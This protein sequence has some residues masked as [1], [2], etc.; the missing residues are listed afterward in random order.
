MK[1]QKIINFILYLN[2]SVDCGSVFHYMFNL[3][4]ALGGGVYTLMSS[5]IVLILYVLCF[6]S[7]T[8]WIGIE[9]CTF[10]NGYNLFTKRLHSY[11][12]KFF[13]NN[14][15]TIYRSTLKKNWKRAIT[16]KKTFFSENLKRR[17]RSY[18]RNVIN[19]SNSK[20]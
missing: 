19:L 14:C 6:Y 3:I 4:F 1:N 11:I 15:S 16:Q 17:F 10:F 2:S 9:A 8:I 20:I 12:L 18:I 13:H 5:C 7:C